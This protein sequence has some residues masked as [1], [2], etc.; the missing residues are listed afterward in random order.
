MEA[1][2]NNQAN[3]GWVTVIEEIEGIRA[4]SQDEDGGTLRRIVPQLS[5]TTHPLTIYA[6]EN[7]KALACIRKGHAGSHLFSHK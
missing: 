2:S 5:F 6:L 3:I 4:G 1:R 7:D